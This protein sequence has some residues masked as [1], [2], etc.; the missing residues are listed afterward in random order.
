[1][2][3]AW[4]SLS[5]VLAV[6]AAAVALN[7]Y[8]TEHRDQWQLLSI[9]AVGT[10]ASLVRS[11]AA[12]MLAVTWLAAAARA[13]LLVQ[14]QQTSDDDG[15]NTL[16]LDVAAVGAL[17]AAVALALVVPPT[18][19]DAAAS[20]LPPPAVVDF[21]FV[22]PTTRT[23]P[24]PTVVLVWR[25]ALVGAFLVLVALPLAVIDALCWWRFGAA[26]SG[27]ALLLVLFGTDA[28]AAADA[29]LQS[30]V[31]VGVY[32][33]AFCAPQALLAVCAP[34]VSA[35]AVLCSTWFACRAADRTHWKL[36]RGS[37]RGTAVVVAAA[38][39]GRAAVPAS[40]TTALTQ[41]RLQH[42]SRVAHS[43]MPV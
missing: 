16:L 24:S 35:A 21:C 31:A 25:A 30:A 32:T 14:Q 41:A 27:A 36:R 2:R 8:A 37:P 39:A 33:C 15:D 7:E 28:V 18:I 40:A 4:A 10:L 43:Y 1:M 29:A 23:A 42:L 5:L 17:A 22:E 19:G 6:I 11:P 34:L 9:L 13:L 12:R 20:L 38:V 26:C 3:S